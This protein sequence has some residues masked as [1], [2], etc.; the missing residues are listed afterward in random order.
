MKNNKNEYV[1]GA[2]ED[3]TIDFNKIKDY[4][5]L[6]FPLDIWQEMTI[7]NKEL[8]QKIT[9]KYNKALEKCPDKYTQFCEMVEW[10]HI[11]FSEIHRLVNLR[12]EKT[13]IIVSDILNKKLIE[14]D[15]TGFNVL[16][17]TGLKEYFNPI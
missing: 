7:Y 11:T 17:K 6:M 3:L 1:L 4:D 15:E 5:L 8:Q 12:K 16:N 14:P 2:L 10:N 9:Q 13:Q